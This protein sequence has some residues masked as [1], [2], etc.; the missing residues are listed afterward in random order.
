MANDTENADAPEARDNAVDLTSGL[1][2]TTTLL[3][4]A[5]L[6]VVFKALQVYFNHGPLA[7]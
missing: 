7:G 4:V 6:F 1:V 3:L 5:A 2:L